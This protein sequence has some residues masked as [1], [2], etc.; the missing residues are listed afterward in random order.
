MLPTPAAAVVAAGRRA[1]RGSAAA[2]DHYPR[3]VDDDILRR[4]ERADSILKTAPSRP[5][6]DA[7]FARAEELLAE[8]RE[9]L[10][11]VADD[12]RRLALAAQIA[13]RMADIDVAVHLD[14]VPAPG[15]A[16]APTRVDDADRVPPGQHL[17]P[18]WPVLHTG[19]VPEG[20]PATWTFT[21]TGLVEQRVVL[22]LADLR[23]LETVAVTADMHCVTSWSRLDNTWE[24]V[25]VAAVLD[26]AGVRPQ[27]THALVSGRP[28]YSAN[29]P[30]DVLRDDDVLLAWAHD[31][32]PLPA[33]HGGPLRLVVPKRYAWKSVK[34]AFELRLLDRD[35]P[36]YWEARGY[37]NDGDPWREERFAGD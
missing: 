19:G 33:A 22:S 24:G 37:H 16:R 29:L 10:D 35:V 12:D 14:H 27:A 13:R 11:E 28:A 20:D 31:G 15:V 3:G 4:I 23:A 8:A 34:W 25:P 30:L 9:H 5:E 26:R 18:G 1:R 36:G 2:P 7:A 21:V 17:T 32:A 6:P